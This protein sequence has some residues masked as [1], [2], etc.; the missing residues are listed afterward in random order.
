MKKL[1]ETINTII[2]I[3]MLCLFVFLFWGIF[4]VIRERKEC[5]NQGKFYNFD[6]GICSSTIEEIKPKKSN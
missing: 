4:Y 3:M 6:Y 2:G 5:I 1:D